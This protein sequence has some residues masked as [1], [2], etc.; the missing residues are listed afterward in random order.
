[1]QQV[2]KNLFDKY[3]ITYTQS[4][5][6]QLQ[7][8]YNYVVE[9]NCKFNLTAIVDKNEFAIK[10]IL[11]SVLP[12]KYL[13]ES[14][15][16]IDIGAG[17]GFPSVPLKIL[18]PDIELCMLDS[19]NKRVEFLKRVC[20]ILN[21]ENTSCVHARVEDFAKQNYEQ[22]DV[23]VA[24]GVA[25]LNTLCEYCLPLINLNG[26]FIAYK[27]LKYADECEQAKNALKILN[28]K[29]IDVQKIHLSEIDSE[30]FN[31]IITKTNHSPQIY[32]RSKN[33]PKTMP[34]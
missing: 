17:A 32:P 18:R 19:L 3:Q 6:N 5:L 4:M 13:P 8:F 22:Y 14:A 9:E 33:L 26:I 11:D 16:V 7:D 2:L 30:R 10:H 28:G 21:L 23:C 25:A 12:V 15:K 1:M 27:S 31:I 20:S 34:L 24:R 29:I